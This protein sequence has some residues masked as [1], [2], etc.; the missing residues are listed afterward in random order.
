MEEIAPP[1]TPP[2]LA[3]AAT[4]PVDKTRADAP[5]AG[6]DQD[7]DSFLRLLT[8]QLR[9]QDPLQPIDST[10]FVA[11]LASFST[12]EQLIGVNETL[13][14]MAA[15]AERGSATAW[16]GLEAGLPADAFSSNGEEVT[17]EVPGAPGA[18]TS[19]LLIRAADGTVLRELP[20]ES[21]G[22]TVVWD[23]RDRAGGALIADG[24]SAELVG[25]EGGD[26][27]VQEQALLLRKISAVRFAGGEARLVLADGV[28]V[29]PD[30]VA[31]L[32]QP[33]PEEQEAA[34]APDEA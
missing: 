8:A 15:Q 14:V 3:R 5:P 29:H 22:G 13:D 6:A 16:I 31:S 34:R 28:T 32:R 21:G 11:Q 20:V 7:F 1:Q 19:T 23:G 33:A 24:L 10:E 12:V 17:F 26:L 25:Y 4:G 2:P 18:D 9:N 27:T 30:A